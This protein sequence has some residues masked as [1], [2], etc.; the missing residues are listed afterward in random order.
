[1]M[2]QDLRNKCIEVGNVT[3]KRCRRR[4]SYVND[5]LYS[6]VMLTSS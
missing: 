3:M 6:K 1:M 4:M 2:K 5:P